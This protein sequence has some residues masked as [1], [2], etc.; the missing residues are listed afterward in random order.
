KKRTVSF[1]DGTTEKYEKLVNTIPLPEFIAMTDAPGEIQ[2]AAKALSCTEVLLVN[3][4]IAHPAPR[5]NQWIYVYDSDK[6][7]TRLSYTDLFSPENGVKGQS[8]IQVEVYYSKYRPQTEKLSEILSK[9]CDELV[10]MGLARDHASI[11]EINTSRVKYANVIFDHPRK[12]ALE[13]I[14]NYLGQFGLAREDD[15][16]APMTEWNK[17]LE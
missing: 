14:F 13:K 5:K 11:L 17:K 6:Y 9:V 2:H 3:V 4:V 10:E 16:L 7:A 15:D 1:S 12:A 8:G